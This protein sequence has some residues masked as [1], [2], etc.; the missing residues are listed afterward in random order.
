MRSDTNP[1]LPIVLS[2]LFVTLV[3]AMSLAE[4]VP[5]AAALALAAAWGVGIALLARWIG[6]KETL[7]AWIE[8]ILVCLGVSAVKRKGGSVRRMVA[9]RG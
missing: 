1:R 3:E 2:V 9:M 8:D 4:F 6:K 7:S 5:V